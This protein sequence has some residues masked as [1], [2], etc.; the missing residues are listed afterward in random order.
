MATFNVCL[1]ALLITP[2]AQVKTPAAMLPLRP[3]KTFTGNLPKQHTPDSSSERHS[4]TSS[5]TAAENYSEC[6]APAPKRPWPKMKLRMDLGIRSRDQ[7][8][9]WPL[10][11]ISGCWSR[12]GLSTKRRCY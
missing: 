6:H 7:L 12:H 5:T 9:A 11:Q 8:T 10:Y 1:L 2:S 4:L 3:E